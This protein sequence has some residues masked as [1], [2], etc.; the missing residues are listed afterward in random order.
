ME[1]AKNRHLLNHHHHLFQLLTL[2]PGAHILMDK[3]IPAE[4]QALDSE[5]RH[6]DAVLQGE[7]HP[8]VEAKDAQQ[9]MVDTLLLILPIMVCLPTRNSH[10]MW[11]R[12][13]LCR[14]HQYHLGHMRVLLANHVCKCQLWRRRL[15]CLLSRAR[16]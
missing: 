10:S 7:S 11:R 13:P 5:P 16:P 3:V 8:E 6:P 9:G 14:R 15:R 2:C 12:C 4:I 1:L